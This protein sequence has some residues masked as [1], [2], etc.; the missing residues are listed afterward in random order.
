MLSKPKIFNDPVHGF[1]KVPSGLALQIIDHPWFQRLRRIKQL[2]LTDLVYPGAHHTRF[3]HALGAMHLMG[4]ALQSLRE[5]GVPISSDEEEG[6]TLAILLHDIGHGPF[7]HTL[8]HEWVAG[9][10]HE[11]IGLQV[12]HS[13]NT[14]FKGALDLA[15]AIFTDQY[16]RHFFHQ[17]VSSQLDID[18]I[19]YLR[20]DSFFT[21]VTEGNVGS[22][23]ILKMLDVVDDQIVVE[24][25]GIYSV[26][27][28]LSARRLMYWQVYF[29]KTTLSAEVMITQIIRRAKYLFQEGTQV[30]ST[31][32]LS[33]FIHANASDASEELLSRYM[34]LDDIDVWASIKAWAKDD[35]KVLSILSTALLQRKLFAS[36]IATQQV[37]DDI[38]Q[39][40]TSETAQKLGLTKEEAAWLVVPGSINNEAYQV[41][42]DHIRILKKTGEIL[43]IADA[44]DLPHIQAM[45]QSVKKHYL[46]WYKGVYLP[47]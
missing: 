7:S 8:E 13:L 41:K 10:N 37:P 28:F 25:K 23:R 22:S 35:D 15:I 12:L 1:I 6:C 44:S 3:H 39:Q 36:R 45:R 43:D 20:R 34:E 32:N 21:G 40:L 31:P 42:G 30:F 26:E 14:Q 11:L 4:I 5:K 18:R 38:M 19:D 47:L 16:H 33:F 9:Q 46:C 29:H 2:G 24:E 17:L 27:A